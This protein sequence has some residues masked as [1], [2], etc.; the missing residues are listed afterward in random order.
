MGVVVTTMQ[1]EFSVRSF[2]LRYP[3]ASVFVIG[4]LCA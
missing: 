2:K 1:L 3:E 4:P